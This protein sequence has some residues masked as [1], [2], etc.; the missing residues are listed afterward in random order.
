MHPVTAVGIGLGIF[1]G[2]LYVFL[3]IV[4]RD[5]Y[6]AYFENVSERGRGRTIAW[7]TK[8]IWVTAPAYFYDLI[9]GFN[10]PALSTFLELVLGIAAVVVLADVGWFAY[11][12]FSQ[13]TRPRR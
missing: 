13:G 7:I 4:P 6:R 2:L 12:Y 1:F 3:F 11:K 5:V 9:V 8:G 10:N